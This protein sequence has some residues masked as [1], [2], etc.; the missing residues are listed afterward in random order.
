MM[1]SH[2]EEL[3]KPDQSFSEGDSSCL[4]EDSS[5]DEE[6][7]EQSPLHSR[8]PSPLSSENQEPPPWPQLSPASTPVKK[9]CWQ[10][11]VPQCSPPPR[12]GERWMD[13]SEPDTRPSVHP[14]A[15]ARTP[16][17]Q[18]DFSKQYSPLELFQLTFSRSVMQTIC[19]NT[20]K[21]AQQRLDQGKKFP[22]DLLE[23]HEL[24]RFFGLLISMG[25]VRCPETQDY[26]SRVRCYNFPFP[27]TALSRTRFE[28]ISWALHISDPDADKQNDALKGTEGYDRLFRLR[29]LLDDVVAACGA[30][31]QP[32][33]QLSIDERMVATKARIGSKRY[34]KAKP[35]KWGFKLFVLS[36]LSN[37][38][39]CD[40]SICTGKQKSS[41]GKGASYDAVMKLL[42]PSLG[43]GYQVYVDNRYTSTT[44][45]QDLHDMRFEACRTHR[46]KRKG[47]PVTK[48]N[49]MPR[50]AEKGTMKWIREGQMLYLKWMDSREVK[51]RSSF[52]TAFQGD[53]IV[54]NMRN[55]DGTWS[56]RRPVPTAVKDYNKFIGGVDLSDAL[57]K[58]YSI[59]R[60]TVKWYK[61]LLQHFI[62]IAVVNGFL[63]QK[64]LAAQ[65]QQRPLSHKR[66]RELLAEQ[67]VDFQPGRTSAAASGPAV[68]AAPSAPPASVSGSRAPVSAPPAA[69]PGASAASSGPPAAA[70]GAVGPSAG[71]GC[72]PVPINDPSKIAR[73]Q[74]ATANR[75]RCVHCTAQREHN[76]TPWKC[77]KCDVSLCLIMDR[78]CFL[79]W[80]IDK[81]QK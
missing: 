50:N 49:D 70:A 53:T 12:G 44:L 61:A 76:L 21:K 38:Y 16:G 22:W 73:S 36:D 25:L 29:P 69:A 80:H 68:P 30:F 13:D 66:F 9:R 60:K 58:Y 19:I 79:E 43:T 81:A 6:D 2:T 37:G 64:E 27:R 4:S 28:A 57:L 46:E 63:L 48:V 40:F 1:S 31:Y 47:Y 15:P 23:P 54:R 7:G 11:A 45:F 3:D 33:R 24:Y 8:S 14:F 20:N 52:H 74:K 65:K 51:I 72:F 10:A 17:P 77:S 62:D 75:R 39:T 5:D 35:I 26:W 32:R 55:T 41:T 71:F 42:T 56:P 67:L 59:R 78:N 18:L 34:M